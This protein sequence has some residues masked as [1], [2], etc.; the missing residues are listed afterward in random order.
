MSLKRPT[1]TSENCRKFLNWNRLYQHN[2][3]SRENQQKSRK[4]I[5]KT[6]IE[7]GLSLCSLFAPFLGFR[8]KN[9]NRRPSRDGGFAFRSLERERRGAASA[10]NYLR[11]LRS[12]YGMM[13]P[14]R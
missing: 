10:S 8:V 12:T 2:K 3:G 9:K 7:P 4:D 5:S 1:L 6:T 14:L 11:M 13:P